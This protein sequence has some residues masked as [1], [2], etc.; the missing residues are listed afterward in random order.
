MTVTTYDR[1]FLLRPGVLEEVEVVVAVV[2]VDAGGGCQGLILA[3]KVQDSGFGI[4][5]GRFR[6]RGV[7]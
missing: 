4:Y 5:I 7:D 3:A 6:F 2:E 1:D